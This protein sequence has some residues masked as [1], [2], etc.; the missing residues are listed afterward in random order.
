MEGFREGYFKFLKMKTLY[1]FFFRISFILL[2]L[3]ASFLVWCFYPLVFS[4]SASIDGNTLKYS[5]TV[6][7]DKNDAVFYTLPKAD[8]LHHFPLKREEI[9]DD[10]IFLLTKKEDE[11]FY[12]HFGVDFPKKVYLLGKYILGSE[13]RGG[14]TLTEQWVK[15][16]YFRSHARTFSQKLRESTLSLYFSTRV[17][18][19]EIVTE[20]LNIAQKPIVV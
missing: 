19:E 5:N 18:K 11:N 15:N 10:F 17:S 8:M 12:K 16:K 7:L 6:F 14:S 9:G 4:S 2:F 1:K 13:K 20:Y 3:I